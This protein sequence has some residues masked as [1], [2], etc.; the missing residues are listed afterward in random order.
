[1][2]WFNYAA[3]VVMVIAVWVAY[4]IGKRSRDRQ[5]EADGNLNNAKQVVEDLEKISQQVR[6]NLVNHHASIVQFKE[7]INALADQP[8]SD[9]WKE[10]AQEAEQ[11]LQPTMQLA[12][13]IAHA[14]DDIRQQTKQLSSPEQP[15]TDPLTGLSSR[16]AMEDIM[17]LLMAMK[18]RYRTRFSIAMIDIDAFRDV[19]NE[20]GYARGDEMLR[21]FAATLDHAVRDTDI[22][23]RFGGEEF[24]VVLP[25]TDLH[26]AG[27]FGQRFAALIKQEFSLA[28][29]V[30]V[31]E[32]IDSDTIQSLMSRTD[33]A[34]YSAKS[35]GGDCVF[36][37]TGRLIELVPPD[38]MNVSSSCVAEQNLA[39]LSES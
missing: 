10:L 7:R 28:T 30:G 17:K 8:G 26:G 32:A 9:A 6:C 39:R 24:V 14:Y 15:R 1:M 11:I 5:V 19:N 12:G 22:V 18:G 23:V 21:A 16:R 20:C 31:A 3:P 33:S 2:V 35:S 27:I 4:R 38:T 37:H 25:E 36:Q 13:Q 34:L 29:S